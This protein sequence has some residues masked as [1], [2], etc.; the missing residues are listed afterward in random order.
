MRSRDLRSTNW[1]GPAQT[2]AAAN[3]PAFSVAA[4]GETIMPAR[5]LRL[6]SSGTNGSDRL[7][8]T[9]SAASASTLATGASSALRLESGMDFM[10]SILNLTAAASNAVPSWNVTF[11]RSVKVIDL[12]SADHSHA[13]ASCGTILRSGEISTSLSH[14]AANTKRPEYVPL[15]AGSSA[16]GSSWMPTRNVAALAET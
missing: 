1:Y 16:S 10:R 3:S 14:S 15:S 7:N 11:W 8:F 2:G 5:S 13:S 6:A 9:L 4:L 12:P